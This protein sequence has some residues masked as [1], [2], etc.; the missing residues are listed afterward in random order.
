MLTFT[1][2][3]VKFTV[4]L[5]IFMQILTGILPL[6]ALFLKTNENDMVVKD[7]LKL[8]T[9][10]QF[11]EGIFY[12]LVVYLAISVS[13]LATYRYFD[14]VITTPFM[15]LSTMIFMEWSNHKNKKNKEKTNDNTVVT[16]MDTVK[17]YKKLFITIGLLNFVMLLFGFLGETKQ[18]HN[19]VAVILG[20]IP[21]AYMFGL[22]YTN[23]VKDT[24][25]RKS[26]KENKNLFYFMSSIWSLY[27]V[28]AFFPANPK[29]IMYNFLDIIAKNFYGL[30]LSYK[31]Y[32]VRE[33]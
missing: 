17:K 16:F 31:L 12:I 20:F 8:E 1:E 21:F 4:Y 33:K 14:W 32:Q 22:M 10:V 24:P 30:F 25:E 11:V 13:S 19:I 6:P 5:S 26:S 29:N 18:M 2:N 27:G 23:F 7:V 9:V 3:T 15:L 28:A